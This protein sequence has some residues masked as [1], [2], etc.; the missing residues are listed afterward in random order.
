ITNDSTGTTQFIGNAV[1]K[2]TTEGQTI[3]AGIIFSNN[4][5]ESFIA[6]NKPLMIVKQE[7]DSIYITADTL[8]SARLTDLYGAKDSIRKDTIKGLKVVD[9]K[10]KDSTNRY[11]EA[12]HHV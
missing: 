4:K 8:F 11:F 7:A 5:T 3:I 6:Y 12:Y 9:V 1:I 2:D 10:T